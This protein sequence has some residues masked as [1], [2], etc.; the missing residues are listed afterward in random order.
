[1][2]P[3]RPAIGIILAAGASSRMGRPKALL[4]LPDG[5]PL[6]AWQADRLLAAGCDAAV[7]VAG[8]AAPELR[9]ALDGYTVVEHAGWALGRCGS[10]QAGLRARPDAAGWLVLPVDNV[11]VGDATLRAVCGAARGDE[12]ALR[13]CC[14]ARRGRALWLGPAGAAIVRGAAADARVDF[15]LRD[16][17]RTL[18]TGDPQVDSDINTPAEWT[19]A[20]RVLAAREMRRY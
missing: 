11:L 20:L 17:E 5:S 19:A 3:P 1:M 14:G 2:R 6:A 7:I 13:P 15:L 4:S 8:A 18:E 12:F 10:L 9:A 16:R